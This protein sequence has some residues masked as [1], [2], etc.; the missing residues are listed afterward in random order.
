MCSLPVPRH[1]DTQLPSHYPT[2]HAFAKSLLSGGVSLLL[3]PMLQ[4]LF[5]V[6]PL[7]SPNPVLQAIEGILITSNRN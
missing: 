3:P 2:L 7:Q 4:D 1:G 5:M 6:S